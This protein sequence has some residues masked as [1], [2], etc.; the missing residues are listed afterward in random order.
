VDGANIEDNWENKIKIMERLVKV[1]DRR[2][3]SI[4][5]KIQIA[6]TFLLSQFIYIMQSI[7]IPDNALATINTIMYKFIWQRKYS[8]KRAFEKVKRAV[9]C[10]DYYEGG[11][12]V[13]DAFDLQNSFF[14][15]WITQL[16]TDCGNWRSIPLYCLNKQ[17]Y[18]L[19][20]LDSSV[21]YKDFIG[22]DLIISRFW[23]R[24]L[25]S[26]LLHN[27]DSA[28]SSDELDG[29]DIYSQVLWN[30]KFIVYKQKTLMI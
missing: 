9:L 22:L 17:G 26:W 30:N 14:L 25:S 12:N 5:G 6:K 27:R 1:W 21:L 8:N 18:K 23:K 15:S 29:Q 3:L 13:I 16:N 24:V 4:M 20:V 28:C 7:G 11:L 10:K 19:S 2:D